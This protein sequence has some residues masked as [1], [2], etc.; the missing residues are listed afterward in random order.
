MN[1][2]YF[3]VQPE[4]S[5]SFI[6]YD[7]LDRQTLVDKTRYFRHVRF[8]EPVKVLMDGKK[9]ISVITWAGENGE[10]KGTGNS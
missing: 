8:K 1:V 2:G 6:K 9:R 10:G 4:V 7:I 3:T 5:K